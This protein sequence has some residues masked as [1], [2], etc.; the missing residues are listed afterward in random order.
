M[1]RLDVEVC[2]GSAGVVSGDGRDERSAQVVLLWCLAR[3]E[4]W[5]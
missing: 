5:G 1:V 4:G 2:L 3:E